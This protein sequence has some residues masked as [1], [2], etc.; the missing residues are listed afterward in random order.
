MRAIKICFFNKLN[1]SW[2]YWGFASFPFPHPEF[3]PPAQLMHLDVTHPYSTRN[4]EHICMRIYATTKISSFEIKTGTCTTSPRLIH[5]QW[6]RTTP[7]IAT[8]IYSI[9]QHNH[10]QNTTFLGFCPFNGI[11]KSSLKTWINDRTQ[12]TLA[13]LCTR[14]NVSG[15]QVPDLNH[16]FDNTR[17]SDNTERSEM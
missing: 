3:T 2:Q 16:G 7:S 11:L 15:W 12:K 14:L 6:K 13:A 4:R 17:L 5:S 1:L 9:H 8:P 10:D